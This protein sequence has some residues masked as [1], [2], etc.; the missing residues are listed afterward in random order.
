MLGLSSE[1]IIQCLYIIGLQVID[2]LNR[3]RAA[4]GI[5]RIQRHLQRAFP[6]AAVHA[7]QQRVQRDKDQHQQQYGNTNLAKHGA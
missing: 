6:V 7:I 3:C 4:I 2:E 1:K 5:D